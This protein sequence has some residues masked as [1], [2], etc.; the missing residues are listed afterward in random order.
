MLDG[1]LATAPCSGHSQRTRHVPRRFGGGDLAVQRQGEGAK[2]RKQVGNPRRFPG[3]LRE[4]PRSRPPLRPPS[5]AG[6]RRA[7][8]ARPAPPSVTVTGRGSISDFKA[9]AFVDAQPGELVALAKCGEA[10]DRFQAIDLD[11]ASARC[12]RPGRS[13]VSCT[14]PVRRARQDGRQQA[15]KRVQ[16]VEQLRMEDVALHHVDDPVRCRL[17]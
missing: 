17:R 14:S 8:T 4:R 10:F 9:I 12:R 7:E 1:Q 5:P 11:A 15:A 3:K 6:T 16:Q 13:S 2:A